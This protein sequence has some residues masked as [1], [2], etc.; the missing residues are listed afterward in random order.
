MAE[1]HVISEIALD[2]VKRVGKRLRARCPI[3]HSSDLDLSLNP[4]QDSYLDEEDARLAGYGHCHSAKC[5]ATVLV[6]E[7]NKAAASRLLGQAVETGEPRITVS[8]KDIQQAEEWQRRELAALN[9][10]YGSILLQLR[11]IR[12]YAYLAQRGLGDQAALDLLAALGVGYVPP[13]N[14]WKKEPPYEL[15]KWCDRIVFPFICRNGERGYVGRALALWQPGMDENEHKRL[16]DEHDTRMEEEHG[17]KAARH[18]IRRWRKTYKSGFFNAGILPEHRHIYLC[19]GPFDVLPLLLANLP[20]VAI[21]G[22]HLDI[23]MIKAEKRLYDVTLAYDLDTQ[24][25]ALIARTSDLLGGLGVGTAFITPPDDQGGKDWSERYRRS[26]LAGLAV[27]VEAERQRQSGELEST[28]APMASR[29]DQQEMVLPEPEQVMLAEPSLDEMMLPPDLCEDC[30]ASIE[31]ED[32]NFFYWQI[33]ASLAHCYCDR[34]RNPETGEPRQNDQ[35]IAVPVLVEQ[36]TIASLALQ[37]GQEMTTAAPI[38]LLVPE[39]IAARFTAALPSFSVEI[40]E[41]DP[42]HHQLV[43]EQS[44]QD[45]GVWHYIAHQVM[46]PPRFHKARRDAGGNPL[47]SKNGNII[48]ELGKP[49]M[50]R[51]KWAKRRAEQLAWRPD[52]ALLAHRKQGYNG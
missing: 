34:C 3:H 12:A 36:E 49:M 10:I 39:E 48:Y 22:T 25:Q 32:R 42:A 1:I 30:G 17:D 43:S 8:S 2:G 35:L 26:G 24:G 19:E 13:A 14:E 9:K 40:V 47:R 23:E 27:L 29:E 46:E 44:R 18:Q 4:Y 6:K 37:P 15:R 52:P 45:Q 38:D 11:H 33:S 5:G 20:A 28:P 21:I 51:E 7:W 50:S 41:G 31:L 16:L